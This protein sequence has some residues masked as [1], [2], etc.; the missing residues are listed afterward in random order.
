MNHVNDENRYQVNDE[1]RLNKI[2]QSVEQ[3]II[4][5]AKEI[6]QI[7]IIFQNTLSEDLREKM[8]SKK[9]KIWQE[10]Q[11]LEQWLETF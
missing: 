10:I 7:V 4:L 2:K 11:N 5:K 3:L 9:Q 1:N 8:R 6:Q